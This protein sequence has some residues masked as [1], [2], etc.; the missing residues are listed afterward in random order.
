VTKDR[1]LMRARLLWGKNGHV[2]QYKPFNGPAKVAGQTH[3]THSV[4]VLLGLGGIPFFSTKA[5]GSS[6]EEAFANYEKEQRH[7][8][9]DQRWERLIEAVVQSRAFVAQHLNDDGATELDNVL[10][11]LLDEIDGGGS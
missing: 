4:G 6:Y 8:R 2:K 1:A 3:D 10:A 9:A 7:H 5:S 11:Q